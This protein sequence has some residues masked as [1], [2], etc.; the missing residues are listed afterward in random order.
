[1]HQSPLSSCLHRHKSLQSKS[2]TILCRFGFH[3]GLIWHRMSLF[4]GV[5]EARFDM[6]ECFFLICKKCDCVAIIN[7][8]S[9]I[10]SDDYSTTHE[11]TLLKSDLWVDL[12]LSKH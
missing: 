6:K 2:S 1:M 5:H 12:N 10:W 8:S 4:L 9:D 7:G 3:E 11:L